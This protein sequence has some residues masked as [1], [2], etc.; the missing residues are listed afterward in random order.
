MTCRILLT[1]RE[2]GCPKL[3]AAALGK[4][5]LSVLA[6]SGEIYHIVRKAGRSFSRNPMFV[7]C[8]DDLQAVFAMIKK[9][10]KDA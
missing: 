3:K 2:S 4:L 6:N 1:L 9:K 5:G 8:H 10:I 7:I